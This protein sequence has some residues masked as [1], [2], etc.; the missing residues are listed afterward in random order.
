MGSE[1]KG[2]NHDRCHLLPCTMITDSGIKPYRWIMMLIKLKEKHG[3]LDG[4]AISDEDGRVLNSS[5][6]DQA[7]HEV[8]EE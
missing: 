2:E 5:S 6:I 7:M 1:V 3:L 8:L 4:L